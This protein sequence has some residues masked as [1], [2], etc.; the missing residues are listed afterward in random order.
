MIRDGNPGTPS[1][2]FRVEC[3]DVSLDLHSVMDMLQND[4]I[5]DDSFV[6]SFKLH[7]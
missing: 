4:S 1:G 2:Y 7:L 3:P 5:N 6:V